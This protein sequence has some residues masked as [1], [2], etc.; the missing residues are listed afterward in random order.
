MAAQMD[1]TIFVIQ[2]NKSGCGPFLDPVKVANLPEA[3]GPGP[4]HRV[5]RE[6]VQHLVDAALDQ[7]KIFE[8]LKPNQGDGKVIITASFEDKMHKLRLPKI[9]RI[10]RLWEFFDGFFRDL[11]CDLFY[12]KEKKIQ[13]FL[14]NENY[15]SGS[16][17]KRRASSDSNNS[18]AP[19]NSSP[20]SPGSKLKKKI[21]RDPQTSS[22]KTE[23]K[24]SHKTSGQVKQT[25]SSTSLATT[26]TPTSSHPQP[27]PQLSPTKSQSNAKKVPIYHNAHK[28]FRAQQIARQILS[29]DGETSVVTTGVQVSSG[30]VTTSVHVA[31]TSVQPHKHPP[32]TTTSR[33]LAEA[34]KL[35]QHRS[36]FSQNHISPSCS[37]PPLTVRYPTSQAPSLPTQPPQLISQSAQP[38]KPSLSIQTPKPSTQTPTLQISTITTP[39]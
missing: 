39:P 26:Q 8:L 38:P 24:P 5:L 20:R 13:I 30:L 25:S 37:P 17:R 31:R 35:S 32:H 27:Q 16:S 14:K 28:I 33:S 3:F 12:Q 10:D 7:R 29:R 22:V 6:S 2:P 34:S 23:I 19:T 15:T 18:E 1:L 4:L 9:E 21:K 11:K 36:Q